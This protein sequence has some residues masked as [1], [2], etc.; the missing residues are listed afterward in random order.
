VVRATGWD[1]VVWVAVPAAGASVAGAEGA[2][3][4]E[5]STG[6]CCAGALAVAL[7]P[8]LGAGVEAVSAG[9]AAGA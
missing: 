8:A 5:G 9:V 6:R 2:G 4:A 1:D 3:G 7:D